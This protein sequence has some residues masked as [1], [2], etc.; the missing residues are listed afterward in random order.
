MVYAYWVPKPMSVRVSTCG[1]AFD[2]TLRAF[3]DAAD[4]ATYICNDDDPTCASPT[5]SLLKVNLQVWQAAAGC[6]DPALL[7]VRR[8]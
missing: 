3:T 8:G 2:T 5:C 4:H 1:S 6:L 7:G